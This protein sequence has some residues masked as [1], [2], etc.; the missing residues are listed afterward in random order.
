MI[1]TNQPFVV[2][3]T[4]TPLR[5]FIYSLDLAELIVRVLFEYDDI[6]PIILSVSEEQEVSIRQVVECIV[7]AMEFKGRVIWDSTKG[8]KHWY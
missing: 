6:E 2:A 4:G 5:Q 1:E 8:V 3:G 7:D